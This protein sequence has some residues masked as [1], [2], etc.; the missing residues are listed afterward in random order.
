[1]YVTALNIIAATTIIITTIAS[2]RSV[3][4]WDSE[5]GMASGA[6]LDYLRHC[7]RGS[8][9]NARLLYYRI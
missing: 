8:L 2:A 5:T 1:M 4:F 3:L 7:D 9:E 6:E